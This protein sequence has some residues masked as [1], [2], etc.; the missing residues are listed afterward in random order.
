MPISPENAKRYPK[1]WPD[2]RR[3][4]MARALNRCECIGECGLHPYWRCQEIHGRKARFAKGK[5]VLTIAHR[6]HNPENCDPENLR[7][8]CQRCHNRY[9]QPHRRENARRTREEKKSQLPLQLQSA[10]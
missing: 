2:I 8:L 1:I 6:D 4:I 10:K 7:A 9:D 5:I 3:R